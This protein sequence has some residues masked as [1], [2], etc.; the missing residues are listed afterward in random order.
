[1]RD[2]SVS[3]HVFKIRLKIHLERESNAGPIQ[4]ASTWRDLRFR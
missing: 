1:M 4:V 2:P 3:Q